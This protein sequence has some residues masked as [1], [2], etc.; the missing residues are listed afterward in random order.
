MISKCK[1]LYTCKETFEDKHG[2]DKKY[3]KVRGHCH[4]TGEY[5]GSALS[6]CNLRYSITK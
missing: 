5:T 3:H 1:S 2:K 4:Y 6:L